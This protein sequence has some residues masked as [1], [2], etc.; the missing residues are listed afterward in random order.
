MIFDGRT[1]RLGG[2]T[3]LLTI[4][5]GAKTASSTQWQKVYYRVSHVLDGNIRKGDLTQREQE[6]FLTGTYAGQDFVEKIT[7]AGCGLAGKT[8]KV[9]HFGCLLRRI[10]RAISWPFVEGFLRLLAL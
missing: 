3:Q 8:I 6:A 1:I 10:L 9:V 4:G 5:R 2:L 7:R